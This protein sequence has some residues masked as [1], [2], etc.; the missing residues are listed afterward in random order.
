MLTSAQTKYGQIFY[1]QNDYYIAQFFEQN[2]VPG[3]QLVLQVLHDF[4][5]KSKVVV[6]CGA[7]VGS[8]SILYKHLNPELHIYAFELQSVM[9]NIFKKNVQSLNLQHMHLF[10]CA[11]GNRT[12]S[13]CVSDTILDGPGANQIFSYDQTHNFGG[14]QVGTSGNEDKIMIALDSLNLDRCDFMKID[15]EGC[16]LPVVM[17]SIQTIM[18]HRPVIFYENNFKTMTDQMQ[19]ITGIPKDDGHGVLKILSG[20]GYTFKRLNDNVLALP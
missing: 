19:Q 14:V 4:I 20:L 18:K 11:L 6:D 1:L 2:T 15:V 9:Y 17:G 12:C 5:K 16:E 8:H 7:H 13:V 3:E 10:N